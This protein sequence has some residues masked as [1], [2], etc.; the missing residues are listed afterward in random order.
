MAR[1]ALVTGGA[2]FIGSRLVRLLLHEGYFVRV[3][4]IQEGRLRG[5]HGSNLE[6]VGSGADDTSGG[7]MDAPTVD[8]AID[9][10][11][12]VYHLA[13]NWDG[14]RWSG[15]RPLSDLL[16]V[17]IRGTLNL[18]E[19]ARSRAV[20]HFLYA[21]SIAVYGKRDSPVMDEETICKPELWRGGPGPGYAITKLAIERLCL[22][23]QAEHG[24]PVTVF[25][26]DVVF[27]DDEF[28]DLSEETI[29]MALHG[30]PIKVN[31]AEA[32][33]S[34]HVDDVARAFLMA[35]LNERAYGQVFNLSNPGAYVTDIEVLQ[36]LIDAVDSKSKIEFIETPQI[37]PVIQSIEKAEALLDWKPLKSKEDLERAIIRMAQRASRRP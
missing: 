27:D 23:Y 13:L 19:A 24:L 15:A 8:R 16:N 26:I 28:Q 17:N 22:M 20:K 30:K 10:V 31:R 25:R 5:E 9:G 34:I 1:K 11:D 21:S 12:V 37:G 29:R 7:M 36:L 35:T 32:G 4:D 6:F 2:G 3:L 14:H 18:L 33:A